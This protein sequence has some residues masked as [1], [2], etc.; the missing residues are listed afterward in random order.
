MSN[1]NSIFLLKINTRRNVGQ[2]RGEAAIRGHQHPPQAQTAEMICLLTHLWLTDGEVRIA[3]VQM[4]QA[5]T[6]QP[7][8]MIAQEKQQGVP[9]K[10][11]PASTMVSR[12]RDFTRMNPPIYSG[13]KIAE[14]LKEECRA[15]ML[16]TS[17]CHSKIMIHV[18]QVEERRK[19]KHTRAGKGQG[20]LRRIF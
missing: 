6:L 15:S 14:N 17:M 16:H 9:R 13:S 2:G 3:L 7:Q 10:N 4:A 19:R 20:K 8:A 1:I 5:I 11:L 12:L 18:Q